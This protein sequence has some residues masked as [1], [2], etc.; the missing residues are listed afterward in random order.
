MAA[1]TG[2]T[3]EFT[4]TLAYHYFSRGPITAAIGGNPSTGTG[5]TLSVPISQTIAPTHL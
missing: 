3:V 2:Q 5:G 1:G 4:V